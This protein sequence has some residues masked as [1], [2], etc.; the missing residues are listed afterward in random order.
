MNAWMFTILRNLFFS[1]YR[2]GRWEVPDPDG[3]HAG[4]LRTAPEQVVACEFRELCEALARLTPEHREALILIGAQGMTYE[5][6]S[7]V[8]GVALG[9]IKSRVARARGRL[10]QLLAVE[11]ADDFGPDRVTQAVLSPVSG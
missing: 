9:T 10:A 8:T 6:A 11:N 1:N 4:R 7:K 5:E 3:V 2:K